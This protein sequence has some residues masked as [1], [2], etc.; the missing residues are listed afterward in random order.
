MFIGFF[1]FSFS[2]NES[3]ENQENT[4]EECENQSRYI[5]RHADITIDGA[6]CT[7]QWDT[8]NNRHHDNH[9]PNTD[10]DVPRIETHVEIFLNF[11][12]KIVR[13]KMNKQ[14]N[15]Q[16]SYPPS[17]SSTQKRKSSEMRR[18]T[19]LYP[20]EKKSEKNAENTNQDD[21]HAP[22]RF[23]KKEPEIF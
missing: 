1:L 11:L 8:H 5:G 14:N 3:S 7:S 9:P 13:K 20:R 4:T 23:G 16:K 2:H 6:R 21:F 18:F 17:Y 15:Q 22:R 19:N 10:I 12:T